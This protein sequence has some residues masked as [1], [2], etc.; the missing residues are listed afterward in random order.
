M[1]A[2]SLKD[3]VVS[4]NFTGIGT[5]TREMESIAIAHLALRE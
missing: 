1:K 4:E 5:V 3:G 2:Y